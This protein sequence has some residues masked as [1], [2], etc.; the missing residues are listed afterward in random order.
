[1]VEKYRILR[2]INRLDISGP[3]YNV[4]YLSHHLPGP[5]ET[6]LV[7][8]PLKAGEPSGAY[9][10]QKLGVNIRYI[11]HMHR[12]LSPLHD[13][14][15]YREIKALI[16]EYQP[17]I[18]HTHTAK[19]GAIGRLAALHCGVPVIVHTFHGHYLHAYFSP[20]TTR[21]L[22]GVERYLGRRTSAV[23]AISHL[24]YDY[25]GQK[26]KV[27]PIAKLHLI[28]NGFDLQ[29]FV[30]GH[31]EKRADFRAKYD[32]TDD[33]VAIGIVGRITEIKNHRFFIETLAKLL[34][35][36]D[37][38]I[39]AFIIGDGEDR[40]LIEAA[41]QE[42]GIDFSDGSQPATLTFTSW[43][44]NV[45]WCNAGL[46]IMTL[47][48]LNEGT[49]VSLVEAQA[50][51]LPVVTTRAGGVADILPPQAGIIIEQGDT[52]GFADHLAQLV[53]SPELRQ[54]MGQAGRDFVMERFS[55]NRLCRDMAALYERLLREK[56]IWKD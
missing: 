5:Y 42:A 32:V 14:K 23:V 31:A 56:G 40:A 15:G 55:Y 22:A 41:A 21:I 28:P 3:V 11:Q 44:K 24:M 1:M 8:G 46:D 7:A 17:H 10:P 25:Y 18:V 45:D 50:S 26:H 53:A 54:Q 52:E 47:T 35:K 43:I 49:P 2:I 48:S 33:Q 12:V 16:R 30:D 38:P 39:R 9:I 6:L 34:K 37:Q 19:P 51:G 4:S 29:R 20:M 27:C 13:W 36:T